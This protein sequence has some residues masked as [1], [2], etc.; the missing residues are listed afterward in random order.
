MQD[1]DRIVHPAA[2]VYRPRPYDGKVIFFQTTDWPTGHYW[3]LQLGWTDLARLEFQRIQ[4]EHESIFH[5]AN[6]EPLA[7]KL[8]HYLRETRND[9]E[10]LPGWAK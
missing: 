8:M 5:E 1:L 4:G 7:K 6:V 3:N 10:Q 2:V 9:P